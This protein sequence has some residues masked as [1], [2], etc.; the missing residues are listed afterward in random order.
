MIFPNLDEL[1][2]LSIATVDNY[3]NLVSIVSIGVGYVVIENDEYVL[4]KRVIDGDDEQLLLAKFSRL[5]SDDFFSHNVVVMDDMSSFHSPLIRFGKHGKEEFNE[6]AG[7]QTQKLPKL[8]IC[9]F[10]LPRDLKF[11][12]KRFFINKIMFPDVLP[13][14]LNLENSNIIDIK[15]IYDYGQENTETSLSTVLWA[16]GY[17]DKLNDDI[18]PTEKVN[19]SIE[20]Y[21]NI[22]STTEL[23]FET[24]TTDVTLIDE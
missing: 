12:W 5:L 6:I 3:E 4:R 14:P 17:T 18:T 10:D 21:Y 8:N 24:I 22:V 19:L 23:E 7:I 11:L 16:C 2:F 1:L 20:A 15:K 13:H 9:G